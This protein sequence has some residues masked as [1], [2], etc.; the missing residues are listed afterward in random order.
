MSFRK[1]LPMPE[2]P[3]EEWMSPD[4]EDFDARVTSIAALA[5]PLRRALYRFVVAQADPVSRDQA[6]AGTG[7]ARHT[8]K[9]HLDK[10]V[11]DGLL[12]FEFRRPPGRRGPGAGRP[13]KVYRR[14]L[15]E[16]SISLPERRYDLAGQLL[17]AA[18]TEMK[19]DGVPP[20]DALHHSVGDV[21]RSLGNRALEWAGSRGGRSA[22]RDAAIRLLEDCGYEPRVGPDGVTL[23]NCPFHTLAQDYRELVC[24]MNLDLIRGMLGAL[25]KAKLE[26]RLDPVPGQCCVK[27]LDT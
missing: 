24:G 7:L 13:A 2:G 5:E 8:A 10:L 16:V 25:E 21:G 6:A 1:D 11:E 23:A 9:F 3:A 22:Q 27:V 15:R 17:A 26:A 19:Q 14:S 20:S 4:H 18:V 12:E